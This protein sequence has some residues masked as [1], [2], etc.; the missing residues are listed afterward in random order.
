MVQFSYLNE[1]TKDEEEELRRETRLR[2]YARRDAPTLTLRDRATT[3]SHGLVVLVGGLAFIF[4]MGGAR[5]YIFPY[6]SAGLR[7]A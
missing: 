6:I 1:D 7:H 3:R 4:T 5:I 2:S